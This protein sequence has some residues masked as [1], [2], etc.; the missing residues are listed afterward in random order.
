MSELSN[1][2]KE[3]LLALPEE[4]LQQ[5]QSEM[6]DILNTLI[7]ESNALSKLFLSIQNEVYNHNDILSFA[8]WLLNFDEDSAKIIKQFKELPVFL[9]ERIDSWI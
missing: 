4:T 7:E 9:E 8:Q 6:F 3:K 1:F 5:A 2:E